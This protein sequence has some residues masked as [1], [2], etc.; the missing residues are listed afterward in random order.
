[1]RLGDL[2]ASPASYLD[3]TFVKELLTAKNFELAS[4]AVLYGRKV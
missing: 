3:M 4:T 1:M 2:S